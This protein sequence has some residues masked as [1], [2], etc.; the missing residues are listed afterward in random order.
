MQSSGLGSTIDDMDW[1]QW[2]ALNR[3]LL[4]EWQKLLEGD[5][6]L[7]PASFGKD[8]DHAEYILQHIS[9]VDD[10]LAVFETSRGC[11]YL[12]PNWERITGWRAEDCMGSDFYQALPAAEVKAF[13]TVLQQAVCEGIDQSDLCGFQF[14]L[15]QKRGEMRWYA[16]SVTAL[17]D[18]PGKRQH[19]ICRLKNVHA[20]ITAKATLTEAKREAEMALKARSEFLNAMS[21]ELRTPLNA[22]LGF[23]QIMESGMYGEISNPQYRDYLKHVR[24]SGYELLAQIDDLMEMACIDAGTA[25]V[26]RE[27]TELSDLLYHAIAL[28]RHYADASQIEMSCRVRNGFAELN[29]DRVKLQHCVSHIV[30]NAVRFSRAGDAITVDASFNDQE[31]VISV[32]DTGVGMSGRKLQTLVSA[33]QKDDSWS[34]RNTNG[35]GLGLSMAK[36]F[37]RL[38]GGYLT[39]VSKAGSGTR[40]N[41]H[42]PLECVVQSPKKVV[43]L[44]RAVKA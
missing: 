28:H 32:T 26:H 42:L 20:E 21:H 1:Q 18:I 31:L 2:S 34:A 44:K 36:E 14:Q 40:V 23:T 33:L 38:H 41:I 37:T 12:S 19:I 8:G 22:I 24:E 11:T 16:L 9:A 43:R 17:K 10:I 35:L 29:V 15:R 5:P 7:R 30:S 27:P 4:N 3:Q 25:T 6:S 13:T 39:L